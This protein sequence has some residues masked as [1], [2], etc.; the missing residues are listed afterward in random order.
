MR[1]VRNIHLEFQNRFS[2]YLHI[3]GG[4]YFNYSTC[5]LTNFS[6]CQFS[7]QF[8]APDLKGL[9]FKEKNVN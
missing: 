8:T 9:Y 3:P 2:I 1:I 5:K 4:I 7:L 6:G